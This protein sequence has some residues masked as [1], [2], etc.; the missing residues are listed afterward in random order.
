MGR[1]SKGEREG[2]GEGGG[3]DFLAGLVTKNIL[4]IHFGCETKDM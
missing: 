3:G 2:G 4:K 1:L